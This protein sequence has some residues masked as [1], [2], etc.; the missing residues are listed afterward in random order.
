MKACFACSTPARQ[1]N[2]SQSLDDAKAYSCMQ[3]DARGGGGVVLFDE[4]DI[5]VFCYN[6]N[7][8]V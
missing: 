8:M 2:K 7:A 4:Q 6:E 5:S 3:Y 1:N